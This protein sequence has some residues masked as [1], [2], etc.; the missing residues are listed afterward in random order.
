MNPITSTSSPNKQ[1]PNL[2]SDLRTRGC[3]V[4]NHA[5]KTARDFFAHWQYALS[6]NEE[7]QSTFSEELGFCPQHNWQ[8]HDLSSPWGESIGLSPLAEHLSRMLANAQQRSDAAAI[9]RNMLRTSENCRVCGMQ[10]EAEAAYV[11][12]LHDFVVDAGTRGL[13]E[14]SQGVCL[15]HLAALLPMTSHEIREFLLAVASRRFCEIARHMQSYARKREAL[16][17]DLINAN[18]ED[19]YLRVLVH[20]AGAKLCCAP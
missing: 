2:A 8:L 5:I 20:L 10:R 6:S 19:A 14:Q 16:R 9:V 3:P 1:K 7:A 12:R 4:C 17:R 11:A 18:E 15:R 13:Y